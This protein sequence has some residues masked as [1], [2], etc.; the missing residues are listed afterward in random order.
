MLRRNNFFRTREG[1]EWVFLWY[2]HAG[3][4]LLCRSSSLIIAFFL[5]SMKKGQ[6]W[7]NH[8]ARE[9]K[10]EYRGWYSYNFFR[11][12]VPRDKEQKQNCA[13]C[14]SQNDKKL[15][16][17]NKDMSDDNEMN[18]GTDEWQ[19]KIKQYFSILIVI[20]HPYPHIPRIPVTVHVFQFHRIQQH[21]FH[22]YAPTLPDKSTLF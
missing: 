2:A 3:Y 18:E 7:W 9:R 21:M 14:V 11:W 20:L 13:K 8:Q 19:N 1:R 10:R 12:I 4:L 15:T 17:E 16:D 6:K 5:N 22:S